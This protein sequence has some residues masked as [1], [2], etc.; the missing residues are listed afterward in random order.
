MSHT[1]SLSFVFAS[2]LLVPVLA[3]CP[4]N[5]DQP[6]PDAATAAA[7]ANA[8]TG[9]AAA[10]PAA[11]QT[12]A[13]AQPLPAPKAADTAAKPAETAKQADST[14]TADA[15]APQDCCCDVAG[16]PLATVSMSECNKTRKGQ[17][18]KKDKCE[19]A[20]KATADKEKNTAAAAAGQCCCEADGKKALADQSACTKGKGKCVKMN[21]CN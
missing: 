1:S 15:G 16:Q 20:Q 4:Q 6:P 14:A 9:A 7:T 2:C 5:K 10:D 19:A 17:C 18:V 3:G 12:A 8:D 11:T 21:Q 13:A